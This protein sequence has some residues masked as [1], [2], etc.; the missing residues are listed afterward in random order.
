VLVLVREIGGKIFETSIQRRPKMTDVRQA[1]L[2][3][4]FVSNFKMISPTKPLSLFD[5]AQEAPT[6]FLV[7]ANATTISL[8]STESYDSDIQGSPDGN[9]A[10]SQRLFVLDLNDVTQRDSPTLD[11]APMEIVATLNDENDSVLRQ[12]QPSPQEA[13]TKFDF[14]TTQY[15]AAPHVFSHLRALNAEASVYL[16]PLH[17]K[18]HTAES[19]RVLDGEAAVFFKSYWP[20]RSD[21]S[22]QLM[23]KKSNGKR[24]K[25]SHVPAEYFNTHQK[26]HQFEARRFYAQRHLYESAAEAADFFVRPRPDPMSFISASL[27]TAICLEEV[28][29]KVYWKRRE[30]KKKRM[31][32]VVARSQCSTRLHSGPPTRKSERKIQPQP[33][34]EPQPTPII[35]KKSRTLKRK[36]RKK[37]LLPKELELLPRISEEADT[38]RTRMPKRQSDNDIVDDGPVV[39]RQKKVDTRLLLVDAS[40]CDTK[41]A[42]DTQTLNGLKVDTTRTRMPKSQSDNDIVDDGP[43]VKR[44]KQVDTRLLLVVA[45]PLCD[46]QDDDV[47]AQTGHGLDTISSPNSWELE[48]M[49]QARL[50]RKKKQ[51][52]ERKES[53]IQG[54]TCHDL[55]GDFITTHVDDEDDNSLL[56]E[57]DEDEGATSESPPTPKLS[58]EQVEQ[59]SMPQ[60]TSTTDDDDDDDSLLQE[61]DDDEGATSELPPTPKPPPEQVEQASTPELATKPPSACTSNDIGL[62]SYTLLLYTNNAVKVRRSCRIAGLPPVNYS[63]MCTPDEGDNDPDYVY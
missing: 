45:S 57:P 63:G 35:K 8:D 61:P 48:V 6:Q 41:D 60:P 42:V 15:V 20:Q 32:A 3:L 43:V 59:E 21:V 36:K 52:R 22:N 37:K 38:S 1:M 27:P 26:S 56:Q 19:L 7:V 39:K 5:G 62:G 9:E 50:S 33:S 44:Q 40:P 51:G 58:P 24:V 49:H 10:S 46:A 11:D 13:T 30:E 18:Y 4:L 54:F 25:T 34:I 47:D 2:L 16:M 17:M 53:N 28:S 12:D 31:I 55:E 29:S 23:H 14:R